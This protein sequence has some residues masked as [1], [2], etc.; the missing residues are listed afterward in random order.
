MDSWQH[1]Y[2][3]VLDDVFASED[4]GAD[5]EGGG[6]HSGWG[7]LSHALAGLNL[8]GGG[9]M[10]H[11]L[12]GWRFL[13]GE[14]SDSESSIGS[15][16]ELGDDARF[17][18]GDNASEED[19]DGE[20]RGEGEDDG[21]EAG[22]DEN[23][24]NWEVSDSEVL[25]LLWAGSSEYLIH[26]TC[27][28]QHLSNATLSAMPRSPTHHPRR[29]SSGGSPLRPV[30][31]GNGVDAPEPDEEPI[32]DEEEEAGPMPRGPGAGEGGSV[33]EVEVRRCCLPALLRR[34]LS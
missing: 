32:E 16:G 33:D 15:I 26:L 24:N 3:D 25:F 19:E 8:E 22:T 9:S 28:S 14:F 21:G 31:K 2:D 30:M 1:E 11:S 27:F 23:V 5:G 17:G 10:G 12:D 29:S 13:D 6:L 18:S 4:A 34:Y 7:P 20:D